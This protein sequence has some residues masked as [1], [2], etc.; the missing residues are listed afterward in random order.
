MILFFTL[1]AWCT[2]TTAAILHCYMTEVT[3]LAW[4][5]GR[6]FLDV[7]VLTFVVMMNVTLD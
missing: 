4:C 3:V 6:Y 7:A 5:T 2:N 1:T